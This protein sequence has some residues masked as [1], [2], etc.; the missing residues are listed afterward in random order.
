MHHRLVAHCIQVFCASAAV[1]S[2]H[3]DTKQDPHSTQAP[4][5]SQGDQAH[6][7]SSDMV[8]DDANRDM[9]MIDER[10]AVLDP[11]KVSS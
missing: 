2:A 8:I 10:I 7:A 5:N 6:H 3:S 9:S 1:D 11:C 4:V